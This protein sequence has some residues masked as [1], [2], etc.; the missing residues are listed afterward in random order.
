MKR[1]KKKNTAPEEVLTWL[2]EE[3]E[4]LVKEFMIL[5]IRAKAKANRLGLK[6]E[7]DDIGRLMTNYQ[8][9]MRLAKA[10]VQHVQ[11]YDMREAS[12]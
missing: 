10:G 7:S 3:G 4:G 5:C 11:T 2:D 9:E 8:R 6:L 1:Y 12:G